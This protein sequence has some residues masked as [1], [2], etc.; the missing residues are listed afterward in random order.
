MRPDARPQLTRRL[1]AA[2]LIGSAAGSALAAPRSAPVIT[3]LGDS[4]TAG[5]GLPAAAALPA[6]LQAALARI[7]VTALV[8]GGGRAGA[9]QGGHRRAAS[10]R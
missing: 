5:L 6:Q 7:G 4:I 9:R 1:F 2:G 3:V 10:A 8:R